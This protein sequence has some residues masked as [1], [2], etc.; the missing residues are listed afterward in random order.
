MK[1]VSTTIAV[2]SLGALVAGCATP[3][4]PNQAGGTM[5][6][7]ATGAVLGGMIGHAGGSTAGGALIGG[8]IGALAGALAGKD[9][10]ETTRTHVVQGQPLTIEDVKALAKSG[11]GDDLI[12]SQINSTRTAYKLNTAQIID[13]KNSGVSQKVIDY[14][15]NTRS[16][17]VQEQQPA[18]SSGGYYYVVPSPYPYYYPHYYP[19]HHGYCGPRW[20]GG[21]RRYGHHR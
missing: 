1:T 13:M 14:M 10:D 6:G 17:S 9:I 16:T 2:L 21:S 15:I 7:G 4:G 11:V 18:Y 8:T 5:V 3:M 20:H 12:I 19:Y